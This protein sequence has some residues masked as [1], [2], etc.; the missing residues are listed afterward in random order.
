MEPDNTQ[1]APFQER[2]IAFAGF[3]WAS[4]H[5]DIVM[6]DPRGATL[7]ELT[8]DDDAAG[9]QH[10]SQQLSKHVGPEFNRLALAVETNNGPAVERLLALGL[11]VYPL[12]PKAAQRYRERKNN[13]G[14][15]DDHL[16]ALSFADALRTDG[17]GWRPLKADDP[18]TQELRLLC[19]DEVQLIAQRTALVN[20][21]RAALREYYPAALEAFDDWLSAVRGLLFRPFP[22]PRIWCA[23]ASAAG[24][25]SCTRTAG[26]ALRRL[27]NDWRSLR[28]R[29]NSAAPPRSL[30][31]R[32]A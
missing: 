25:S 15:K 3:D 5:H 19:R 21:L 8:F 20:Q 28:T 16:D 13:A 1:E 6:L 11:V 27:Q 4:D 10:L 23:P 14:C 18:T 22:R 2:F 30:G 7:L 24:R 12:N 17:H 29:I 26:I 31:P 9:W 32:V